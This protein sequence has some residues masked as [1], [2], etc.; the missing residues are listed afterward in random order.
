MDIA[1]VYSDQM[2]K[3]EGRERQMVDVLRTSAS[4]KHYAYLRKGAVFFVYA[5]GVYA[6]SDSDGRDCE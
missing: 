4:Y 6:H 2:K 1:V 3:E 5:S